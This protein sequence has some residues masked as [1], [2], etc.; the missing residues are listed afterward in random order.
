VQLPAYVSLE[1][2]LVRRDVLPDSHPESWP[3][4]AAALGI[5]L[6]E[7]WKTLLRDLPQSGPSQ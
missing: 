5:T 6:P 1:G 2:D 7:N 3:S 4:H